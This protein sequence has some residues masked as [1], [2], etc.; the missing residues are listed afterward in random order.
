MDIGPSPNKK[1]SNKYQAGALSFEFVSNGKKILTN[2]GYFNKN[3]NKLN[4]LSKSSAVHNVLVIDDNSSCKFKKNS[5]LESEIKDG[6]KITSK[7]IINEKN[8]WKIN[9]TH[10]GYFKKY[11]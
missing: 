8:Y 5:N 6:L 4:D 3:T 2:S 10:N 11:N 9:A 1:F 7:K